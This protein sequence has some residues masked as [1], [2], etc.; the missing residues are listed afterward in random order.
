MLIEVQLAT[1]WFSIVIINSRFQAKNS[2]E[3]YFGRNAKH[4][5]HCYKYMHN[6]SLQPFSQYYDLA[7]HTTSIVVL[8]LLTSTIFARARLRGSHRRNIFF[9]L[10]DV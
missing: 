8:A 7:S 9:F 5:Y 1:H 2:I 4:N 6:W 3:N 10:K